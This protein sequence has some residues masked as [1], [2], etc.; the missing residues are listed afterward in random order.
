MTGGQI[1]KLT[2]YCFNGVLD[3]TDLDTSLETHTGGPYQKNCIIRHP[4]LSSFSEVDVAALPVS[5]TSSILYFNN[6]K[7]M[8]GM[9]ANIPGSWKK[10]S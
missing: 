10:E 9:L 8:P 7:S 4:K 3:L 1:D 6:V 2:N 5:L